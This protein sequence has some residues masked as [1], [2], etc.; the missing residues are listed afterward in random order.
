MSTRWASLPEPERFLGELK[1]KAGLSMDF[2]SEEVRLFRYHVDKW[3]E[4]R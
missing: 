4:D 1:R 2:W 3:T